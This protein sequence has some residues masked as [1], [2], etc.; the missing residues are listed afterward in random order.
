MNYWLAKSEPDC[1]SW[2]EFTKDKRTHWNGIRNYAAR[3][4]M[5]SMKVGDEV[6][7][8][9][10]NEGKD[11]VGV[12]RVVREHYPDDSATDGKDWQMVD[13]EAVRP[14]KKSVTLAAAKT[15]PILKDMELVRLGR[16]SVSKVS[17]DEFDRVLM[18]SEE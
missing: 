17:K 18:L 1:Y 15:D 9:H 7:F 16:L 3:L 11:I 8:Y 12:A 14:L 6:L 4:N 5:M 10:S 13:L 2:D